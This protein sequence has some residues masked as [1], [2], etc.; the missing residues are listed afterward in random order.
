MALLNAVIVNLATQGAYHGCADIGKLN[1][2]ENKSLTPITLL[3]YLNF[4][5]TE[6]LYSL[7]L[8]F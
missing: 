6:T 8:L 1:V 2:L 3:T 5:E 4:P 7:S